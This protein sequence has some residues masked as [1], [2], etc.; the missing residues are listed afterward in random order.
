MTQQ[1]AISEILEYASNLAATAESQKEIEA[2][3]CC[4]AKSIEIITKISSKSLCKIGY[5]QCEHWEM[6][7]NGCKFCTETYKERKVN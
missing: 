6:R 4:L 7:A 3:N 2:I 1:E 5:R